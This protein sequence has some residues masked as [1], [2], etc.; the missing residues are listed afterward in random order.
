MQ[1]QPRPRSQTFLN[2]EEEPTNTKS[3]R[4]HILVCGLEMQE[5]KIQTKDVLM[6]RFTPLLLD[7]Y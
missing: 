4:D 7:C 6:P 2:H 5:G 1:P 3:T